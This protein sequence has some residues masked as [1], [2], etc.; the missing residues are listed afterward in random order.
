MA[1]VTTLGQMVDSTQVIMSRIR[2]RVMELIFGLMVNNSK[3]IG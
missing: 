3:V 1:K 2:N